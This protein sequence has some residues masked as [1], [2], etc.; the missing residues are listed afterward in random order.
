VRHKPTSPWLRLDGCVFATKPA[1]LDIEASGF[2]AS[3]Y[4]IEIGYVLAS[5]KARCWLIQPAATW[6]HWDPAAERLHGLSL[7]TVRAHGWPLRE[8][9]A[10]LNEDLHGSTVYCDGW[11]RDYAWLG[12]LFDAADSAPRFKLESVNA[13]LQAPEL[14]LLDHAREDAHTVLRLR[15]HRASSDARAL[16]MAL[17]T[18]TG[19]PLARAA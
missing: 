3:S 4:P 1:V 19:T 7:A 9:A 10:R 17:V 11:A 16:Q 15:R 14:A 5:G 6:L 8:V 2:G 18:V 13:L 12:K